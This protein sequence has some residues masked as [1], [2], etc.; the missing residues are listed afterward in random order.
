MSI[1]VPETSHEEQ[2]VQPLD[3]TRLY[4]VPTIRY[5]PIWSTKTAVLKLVVAT[6]CRVAKLCL[7][8]KNVAF[9]WFF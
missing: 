3:Q 6:Q 9:E 1:F 7:V 4:N 2:Q 8:N 5:A